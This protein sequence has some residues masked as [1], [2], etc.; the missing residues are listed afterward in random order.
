MKVNFFVYECPVILAHLWKRLFFIEMSWHLC[1]QFF[2]L[3][4]MYRSISVLYC[5]HIV[6]VL[7]PAPSCLAY[8][9]FYIKS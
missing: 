4:Y 1:Q 8:Y 9:G 2:F 7:L 5:L 6:S 3:P